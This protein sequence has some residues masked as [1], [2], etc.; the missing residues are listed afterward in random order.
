MK[1]VTQQWNA[2]L[3]QQSC[4]FVWQ[5][6][7]ELLGMLAP[8][9]GESILD[10][11]CGTGQLTAE[12]ASAGAAVL[13]IDRSPAMIEEARKNFPMV[14]FQV[15]DVRTLPYEHEFD[16]VFSNAVLHW[17]QPA[18][19]AVAAMAR[20]LKAGGRLVVE[21]GGHGNVAEIIRASEEAWKSVA[22]GPPPVHPWYYPGIGE[23]ASLLERHDLEV[24]FALLF[25]RPTPL[26]GG[27]QG[28]EHWYKMFGSHWTGALPEEKRVAF[29]R[30]AEEI[31]SAKLQRDGVWTADY[32]RLRVT[33]RKRL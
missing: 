33:A 19:A 3:Y 18:E 12:I 22:D 20:A 29:L 13:G 24:T 32:R 11:G 15:G 14:R 4:G 8:Q 17:V 25:D 30:V 1:A 27:A 23:Y 10:L 5:F 2:G 26:E 21:M 7:K 9:A 31:A 16:A 6:G 28:L